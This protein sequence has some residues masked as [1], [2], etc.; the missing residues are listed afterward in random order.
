MGRISAVLLLCSVLAVALAFGVGDAAARELVPKVPD[1]AGPGKPLP[2][3][4]DDLHYYK[5][6]SKYGFI[7]RAGKMVIPPEYLGADNFTGFGL[8]KVK[9][10]SGIGVIDAENR[11]LILPELADVQILNQ[12]D[13]PVLLGKHH[14]WWGKLSNRGEWLVKPGFHMLTDLGHGVYGAEY[15]GRSALFDDRGRFLTE[16]IYD[17]FGRLTPGPNGSL[18]MTFTLNGKQGIMDS[19]GKVVISPR[20]ESISPGFDENG[21]FVMRIDGLAGVLDISD[22]WIIEPKFYNIEYKKEDDRFWVMENKFV[23]S[24]FYHDMDGKRIG[25]VPQEK[26][27]EE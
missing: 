25:P 23:S 7:S 10:P 9:T 14:N 16:R 13:G 21:K 22:K 24:Y 5:F 3:K 26:I 4:G 17:G 12:D 8:A 18:L 15:E 19:T 1:V 11:F 2:G 20:F 27:W 6:G